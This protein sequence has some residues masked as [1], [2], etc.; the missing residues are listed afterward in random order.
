MAKFCIF[1]GNKPEKKNKEHILPKW[2]SRYTGRYK[3]FCSLEGITDKQIPFSELQFPACTKC[4]SDYSNLEASAQQSMLKIMESKPLTA[5]EINTFLDWFDKIRVGLW[6][7]ELTLANKVDIVQPNFHISQRMGQKDRMLIV[8]R[9]AVDGKGLSFAGTGTQMFYDIPSAFQLIVNDYVF[10]NASEYGLVS[11]KLGFPTMDKLQVS[12]DAQCITK[13]YPGRHKTTH[14]VVPGIDATPN[15]TIIY[16]PIYKTFRDYGPDSPYAAQ[17]VQD[18]SLDASSG[19][20]GIFYQKG[21]NQIK[22]L[23]PDKRLTINPRALPVPNLYTTAAKVYDLQNYMLDN[24]YDV[25]N[26]DAATLQYVKML[27]AKNE[28]LSSMCTR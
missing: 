25:K 28:L 9:I 15:R 3:M 14:P 5:P 16:Q 27:M 1:C 12:R 24:L 6:L 13:L 8:E 17:Y 22:Y 7:A 21:D 2:L 26:S 18:Y 10:T 19:I 20:G 4:N 23:S 11:N